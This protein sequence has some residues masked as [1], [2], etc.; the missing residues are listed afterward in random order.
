MGSYTVLTGG[1][2][3]VSALVDR[4]PMAPAYGDGIRQA[5]PACRPAH[6]RSFVEVGC[7]ACKMA[8]LL[9]T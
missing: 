3:S 8:T 4:L 2:K 1:T 9:I 6:L 7:E 5:R